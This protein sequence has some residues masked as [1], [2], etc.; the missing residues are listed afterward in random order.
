MLVLSFH[1]NFF[2]GTVRSSPPRSSAFHQSE[3]SN[4]VQYLA[5]FEYR[6][7]KIRFSKVI[8][9]KG[10]YSD[11]VDCNTLSSISTGSTD[12]VDVQLTIVR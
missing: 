7:S 8:R 2:Y 1:F 10:S 6:R 11:K 4:T 9:K 12:S 5:E 3:S